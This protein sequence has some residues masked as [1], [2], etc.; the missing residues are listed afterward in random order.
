M[1]SIIVC[2]KSQSDLQA[3]QKQ[4]EQ[5]IGVPYEIIA[6]ENSS[7]KYGIC[8][9]Y[10]LGASQ[11]KYDYLCFMHEDLRFYSQN[12]GVKVV[13]ALQDTQTG[14]LGIMGS[15]AKTK[16]PSGW[17]LATDLN[18]TRLNFIQ[19]FPDGES[20]TSLI[21]PEGKN[22]AEVVTLD[23]CWLCT[24]KDVWQKIPFDQT[25]FRHF[26]LYDLDY[27]IQVFTAGYKVCVLF[28]VSI[29]HLSVGNFDTKWIREALIF[30]KKWKDKLPVHLT[31][32]QSQE[33]SSTE[34]RTNKQFIKLMLKNKFDKQVIFKYLLVCLSFGK[35]DSDLW[36]LWSQFLTG[37]S[38]N[39]IYSLSKR[40]KNLF[41]KASAH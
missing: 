25:T 5:T 38:I 21:N 28:G 39:P 18:L 12:W 13:E 23:G 9:A 27:S 19:K 30:T 17:S 33:L 3:T 36:Y 34:L 7:A 40:I 1:I 14:L 2:S 29:E 37:K 16:A 11:S 15:I 10:N 32:I 20:R 41:H 31:S 8:E 24:R 22:T 6:I 4:V 35:F 26:H